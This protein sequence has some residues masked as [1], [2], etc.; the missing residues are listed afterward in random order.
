LQGVRV[1]LAWRLQYVL[2]GLSNGDEAFYHNFEIRERIWDNPM[3]YIYIYMYIYRERERER[4]KGNDID[5]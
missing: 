3:V 4:E 5:I 1:A 2:E